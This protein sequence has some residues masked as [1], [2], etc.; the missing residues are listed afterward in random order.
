MYWIAH[1]GASYD[2]P[3]NTLS[4]IR[5]AWA[6]QADAIECDV[7]LTADG[8]LV[9]SHDSETRR[10][11][12]EPLSI[13]REPLRR[14]RQ[15]DVGAWKGEMFRG[16]RM[17]TLP[18][19]LRIVP[20]NRGIYIEVKCGPEAA[21]PLALQVRRHLQ[22]IRIAV[23]GFDLATMA[24]CK[25]QLP[26]VPH[27]WLR[28]PEKAEDGSIRYMADEWVRRCRDAALD[29]LDLHFSVIDARTAGAIRAA[30]MG[31]VAWT[32]NDP[33]EARRLL[34]LGVDGIT[35]DRPGW[36]REQSTR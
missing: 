15:L 29:G 9:L 35:T 1:R 24:A 14:L 18:E 5:M 20:V 23:I 13:A 8:H 11:G 33:A 27:F 4:A 25:Q 12:G 22:R 34:Q 31:L 36:L 16:E 26:M 10:T 2:A 28:G 3:E 30:G 7:H 21:R 32:V 19:A 17:P 6:Q